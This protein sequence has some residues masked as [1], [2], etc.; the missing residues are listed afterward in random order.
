LQAKAK[1]EGGLRNSREGK[2]SR[3]RKISSSRGKN[4]RKKEKAAS[5]YRLE[6]IGGRRGNGGAW[7][8]YGGGHDV[9]QGQ[10]GAVVKAALYNE[11]RGEN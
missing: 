2:K 10:N 11:T 3:P 6:W 9:V 1:A 8:K 5:I 7:K 4:R